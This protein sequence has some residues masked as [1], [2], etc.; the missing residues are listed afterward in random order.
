[1][2]ARQ[3]RWFIP[4]FEETFPNSGVRED[5]VVDWF[6]IQR[7]DRGAINDYFFERPLN[8]ALSRHGRFVSAH[9]CALLRAWT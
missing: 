8:Q 1:M 7:S 5:I 6:A 3:L 2:P 4:V 9:V